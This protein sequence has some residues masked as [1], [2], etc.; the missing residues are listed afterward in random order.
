[1]VSELERVAELTLNGSSQGLS[2]SANVQGRGV[3]PGHLPVALMSSLREVGTL[4]WRSPAV[5]DYL[6]CRHS[7]GLRGR[8]FTF[9]PP[10]VEVCTGLVCFIG[11]DGPQ[12]LGRS[13][14]LTCASGSQERAT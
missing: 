11:G 2:L 4:T 9:E 13:E 7:E 1:V 12:G 8:L 6:S 3:A 10:G 14:G 5:L